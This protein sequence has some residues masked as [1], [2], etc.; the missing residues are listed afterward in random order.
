[1]KCE[2]IKDYLYRPEKLYKELYNIN[3]VSKD[4]TPRQEYWCNTLMTPY[5]YGYGKGERTYE[6]NELLNCI[7]KVRKK[8][9][10]DYGIYFEGCFLN[11][12]NSPTDGIGWHSDDD[13]GIDHNFP[14]FVISLGITRKINW[15]PIGSKGN[16]V[17]KER[18]L[19]TGS[20]FIMPAGFQHAYVH[21]IPKYNNSILDGHDCRIS[22]TFRKLKN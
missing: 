19:K 17:I 21:R 8:I 5:T 4:N 1:M 10:K 18:G 20:L 13:E 3:W 16:D 2:Y 9:D 15:K 11:R 7:E 14:I 6:P 22:L 12:Y